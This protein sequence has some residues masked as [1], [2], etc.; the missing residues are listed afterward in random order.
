MITAD[1]GSGACNRNEQVAKIIADN[2][3]P[4]ISTPKAFSAIKRTTARYKPSLMNIRMEA[5]VVI[6]IELIIELGISGRS[7]PCRSASAI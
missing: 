7:V 6:K 1:L 4:T 5:M 2:P 3:L